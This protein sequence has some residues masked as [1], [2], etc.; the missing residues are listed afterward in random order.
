MRTTLTL[1]ETNARR[2]K[3]FARRAGIPF[4]QAVNELI[5]KGLHSTV[6]ESEV[7]PFSVRARP[8]GLRAGIDPLKLNQLADDL[9]VDSF[10]ENAARS[11]PERG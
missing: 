9:E 10:L 11:K 8:M 1:E 4:K 5:A 3:E 2:V 6:A 7:V